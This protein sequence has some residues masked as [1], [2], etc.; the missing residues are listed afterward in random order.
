MEKLKRRE[1]FRRSGKMIGGMAGSAI[2][3]SLPVI[4]SGCKSATGPDEPGHGTVTLKIYN[5]T[6]GPLGEKTYASNGAR[7]FTISIG[8]LGYEG[9][10]PLRIAVRKAAEWGTMGRCLGFSKT[11]QIKLDYPA[12]DEVWEAYLM[13]VGNSSDYSLHDWWY[14]LGQVSGRLRYGRN[15]RCRRED[16]GGITGPSE[17]ILEAVRQINDEILSHAWKKYG[18]LSISDPGS[19]GIG[20]GVGSGEPGHPAAS[21]VLWENGVPTWIRV[22]PAIVQSYEDRLSHFS[23]HL[24]AMLTMTAEIDIS[25][26]DIGGFSPQGRDLLAYAFVKDEGY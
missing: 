26:P 19:F 25:D 13:N 22:D 23:L 11:G 3:G 4:H 18:S 7:D 9:I 1:F 5:H 8:S 17:P 14:D 2:L 6:Q 12:S 24:F 16:R 15:V 10:D 21:E 20:Y